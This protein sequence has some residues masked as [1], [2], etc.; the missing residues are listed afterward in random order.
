MNK[1]RGMYRRSLVLQRNTGVKGRNAMRPLPEYLEKDQVERLIEAA[2]H[3]RARLVMFEQWRAGLRISEAL[4]SC[5]PR[6]VLLI[7][8]YIYAQG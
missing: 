1:A 5:S 7:F 2:P 3:S 6:G 8:G 4:A